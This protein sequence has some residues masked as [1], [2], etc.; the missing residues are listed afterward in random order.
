M[1]SNQLFYCVFFLLYVSNLLAQETHPIQISS[2]IDPGDV[3]SDGLQWPT[4]IGFFNGLEIISDLKN[5]RFVYRLQGS[6]GDFIE[7]QVKVDGQHS[8]TWVDGKYYAV[9]TDEHKVIEFSDITE[10]GK[11]VP[12]YKGIDLRRP[13]D[14][15]YNPTDGYIYTIDDKEGL[16][17]FDPNNDNIAEKSEINKSSIIGYARSLS[18]VNGKVYIINSSRGEV[19]QMDDFDNWTIYES[20]GQKRNNKGQ[21]IDSPAGAWDK[22]G[23]V[24]NDVER[25][26]DYWYGSNYFTQSYAVGNDA[27]V[28]RLIRWRTWEDFQNGNWEDLSDLLPSGVVPY[29]FTVHN[30]A[31]YL[32]TF[33]HEHPGTN[34]K[35]YKLYPNYQASITVATEMPSK[36]Y[37]PMIFGGFIEHFHRQ[38]YGGIF[39]PDSPFADK[40]G[41]RTDV[42]EVLKELKLPV[43][44]W[45]GGC[46]VDGYHWMDGI[47]KIRDSKDDIRWGV[48]EPNTFGTDE[49]VEFCHR[50]RAEPYICHN[51]LAEVQ[52]MTDWLEYCNLTDGKFASLRKH[53]GH[54]APHRVKFWSV[55]NERAGKEYIHKVR[56]GAKGMKELDST[57]LVTCSGTHGGDGR[58]I[59]NYLFETA[60]KYLDYISIHQYWVQNF[61]K[62][63]T[64]DYM[65]CILLSEEPDQY[66]ENVINSLDKASLRDKIKIAFDEWNLRS[67][68]HPGFQRMKKA[69]YEDPETI[70]LIHARNKSLDN[71]LYTM[72]DALFAASFLNACLRHSEDVEMA[73]V[74]PIVN[75]T[76]P[77][78]V[79]PEGLVRRTHFHTMA[80]YANLLEEGV[81]KATVNADEITNN[82]DTVAIIDALAT[83]DEKGKNLAVSLVNR[84]PTENVECSLVIGNSEPLNG[85]YQATILTGE[86]ANSFNDIEYPNRV[87]PKKVKLNFRKGVTTL[88]PHSLTIVH[89]KVN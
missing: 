33:H 5:D 20:P 69:D 48:I 71:S 85:T 89:I 2:Y 49:F 60:G 41:F 58:H 63:H 44:R 88:S 14:I 72:A 87:A 16:T 9:N 79:H 37:N 82:K 24:L 70:E 66:I 8:L 27:N 7:S 38:V 50:L 61:Q 45:P 54:T 81:V 83:I 30:S 18:I 23:L 52:E 11:N 42:I 55:G 19:I 15:V 40:Q 43:I 67:W 31:L 75:Q 59:D 10:T 17:R 86:S 76:G 77:L 57:V 62:H 22:T 47:G 28:Y 32:A 73:N 13:H 65:S 51:G 53:N 39:E 6:T 74:A 78:F 21:K 46:F 25:Y 34:D 56:D 64:P 1:K 80:M 3:Q 35:I 68:H 29:Y 26:G 84:H 36:T 4:H 12:N